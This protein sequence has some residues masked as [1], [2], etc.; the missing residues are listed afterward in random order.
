MGKHKG[1]TAGP[2][3]D[4]RWGGISLTSTQDGEVEF[5][6]SDRE[7]E[8]KRSGN[9][10][11]Y[12]ESEAV[13]P[14]VQQDIVVTAPEAEVLTGLQDGETRAGTATLPNG[15]VLS[16]NCAIDGELTPTNGVLTLKLAGSVKVQ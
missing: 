9:G 16:L 6:T 10:D 4:F 3:R 14:Y 11:T 8:I 15:D 1:V 2:L 13:V 12:S 7:Y 5:K